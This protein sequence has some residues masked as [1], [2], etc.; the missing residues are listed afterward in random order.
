MQAIYHGFI[1][2]CCPAFILVLWFDDSFYHT[3]LLSSP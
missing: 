3:L 1:V 2:W